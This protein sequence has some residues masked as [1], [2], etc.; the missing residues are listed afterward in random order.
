[1]TRNEVSGPLYS[2]CSHEGHSRNRPIA[3]IDKTYACIHVQQSLCHFKLHVLISK[4]YRMIFHC[5]IVLVKNQLIAYKSFAKKLTI[6][7]I[8]YILNFLNRSKY[9]M[10]KFHN[11]SVYIYPVKSKFT[12][13]IWHNKFSSGSQLICLLASWL[14][15][16]ALASRSW[17][18]CRL[19][20]KFQS[21]IE[22]LHVP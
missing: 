13:C 20:S 6:T 19:V 2:V 22:L 9:N 11:I 14:V 17:N 1:M 4:I 18:N 7:W 10:S 3:V 5:K 16:C 8:L 15:A 12:T 21:V